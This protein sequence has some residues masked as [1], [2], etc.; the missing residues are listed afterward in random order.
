MQLLMEIL[1]PPGHLPETARRRTFTT[2]GGRV[3]RN[4]RCEWCIPD[5]G[6]QL[7]GHHA[8]IS[9][10][11]GDFYL[12]DTSSN[13]TWLV[14]SGERLGKDRPHRLR[15]QAVYRLSGFDILVRL[16]PPAD[17]VALDVGRPAPANSIIQDDFLDSDPLTRFDQE[18][19][20]AGDDELGEVLRATPGS[21]QHDDHAQVEALHVQLPTLA[22]AQAP[23]ALQAPASSGF[24]RQLGAPL[25]LDLESLD[26]TERE[27]Q[28]LNAMH[29]LRTCAVELG[30]C[31][32]TCRQLRADSLAAPAT[33]DESRSGAPLPVAEWLGAPLALSQARLVRHFQ[34]LQR[35]QLATAAACRASLRATL[36]QVSPARV[37]L[38]LERRGSR[39]W[40]TRS[41]RWQAFCQ[42]HQTLGD[43]LE[44]QP[45]GD[46][47]A[48]AYAEQ[49]RLLD[50]L[51]EYPTGEA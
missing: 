17:L 43:S 41:A 44:H 9:F 36:E 33:D 19:D 38:H 28:V 8:S 47:F 50:S 22:Q 49:Q 39:R 48:T 23:E 15:N 11:D 6:K 29:L 21:R 32:H 51:G 4:A 14:A 34:Q 5:P 18:D 2:A 16:I 3:G 12:T 13:G 30:R 24:W 20:P 27:R 35:H 45:F 42:L 40:L 37:V 46:H 25:G 26:A 10:H 1:N 31:Q 7:S